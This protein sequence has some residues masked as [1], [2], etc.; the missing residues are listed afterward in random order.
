M[1]LKLL[2]K[3]DSH[4][5]VI[6]LLIISQFINFGLASSVNSISNGNQKSAIS[7]IV[8]DPIEVN[9]VLN[10]CRD[11]FV[12]DDIVIC[13]NGYGTILLNISSPSDPT[14]IQ[15]SSELAKNGMPITVFN[16]TLLFYELG[17]GANVSL[18]K[19]DLAGDL[20]N[21]I[22]IGFL[23]RASLDLILTNDTLYNI[24]P[25][26]T[27]T[28]YFQIYNAT[29]IDNLSL[30]G[31]STISGLEM[32]Y[33]PYGLEFF[34]H[35]EFVY[36]ISDS[37]N[38]KV[39]QINS[40]YQL[41]FLREYSFS[42]LESVYIDENYL[43]TCDSLG[44]QV[45]DHADP[46]DLL[47]ISQYDISNARAIRIVNNVAYLT[48][49]RM[50]TTLDLSNINSI[51]E[52]DHYKLRYREDCELNKI[53]MSGNIAVAL[54]KLYVTGTETSKYTGY[55]YLFDVTTPDDIDRL[56]PVKIPLF[57]FWTLYPIFLVFI[58]FVA[59]A[60]VIA[61]IIV[62]G[63]RIAK[64]KKLPKEEYDVKPNSDDEKNIDSSENQ[65]EE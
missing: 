47:Y 8:D 35:G 37:K 6:F 36:F 15:T 41:D 63:I 4:F 50:F 18:K 51:T 44:I 16:K 9:D 58:Y 48:S 31:N 46:G 64:K 25:K 17:Y 42:Q 3:R 52:L 2:T 26:G 32:S 49:A 14:E 59:P 60:I 54:T 61:F 57:D 20:N 23:I 62:L 56:Y 13:Q 38:L 5:F 40:T 55:L 1:G 27:D 53:E 22:D 65:M 11:L 24:Y 7:P 19:I 34:V 39:Y 28:F 30:L 21:T 10:P 45:F 33:Y 12:V 29:N 43:F